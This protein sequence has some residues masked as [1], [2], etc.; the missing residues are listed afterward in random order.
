MMIV[1]FH[2]QRNQ[3]GNVIDLYET[4]AAPEIFAVSRS[5]TDTIFVVAC[6]CGYYESGDESWDKVNHF[7]HALPMANVTVASAGLSLADFKAAHAMSMEDC[8]SEEADL[9]SKYLDRGY[10]VQLTVSDGNCAC[11]TIAIHETSPRT[12]LTW[13]KT[14]QLCRDTMIQ[15]SG[16]QWFQD[17]FQVAG[18]W[19]APKPV[20]G[21]I[22]VED[23]P[24]GDCAE[25]D[26]NKPLLESLSDLFDAP[27]IEAFLEQPPPPLP[28]P[29][30]DPD[31]PLSSA[32][33]DDSEEE[34]LE[35]E[36]EPQKPLE[37]SD[38]VVLTWALR[39][40]TQ[41]NTLLSD[42]GEPTDQDV[43]NIIALEDLIQLRRECPGLPTE[44]TC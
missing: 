6:R 29:L 26:C 2:E 40:T 35:L 32:V 15:L 9:V 17:V 12:I 33:E 27:I 28:P 41:G 4:F 7:V 36:H 31:A 42:H 43:S 22:S 14:R 23:K 10:A 16:E 5:W 8:S 25:N 37:P 24:A 21:V 39:R 13:G 38:A 20:E 44:H 3:A 19:E 30:G 34:E 18:E 11:D 1:R